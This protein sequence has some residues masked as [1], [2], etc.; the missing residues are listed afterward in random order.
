MIELL[1][2]N[3]FKLWLLKILVSLDPLLWNSEIRIFSQLRFD[4]LELFS[5]TSSHF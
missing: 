3:I 4:I 5:N 1:K 2:R